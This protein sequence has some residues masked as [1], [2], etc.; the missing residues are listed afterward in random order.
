MGKRL[1]PGEGA[2]EFQP[3]DG[4][5]GRDRGSVAYLNMKER[6]QPGDDGVPSGE[7]HLLDPPPS[8]PPNQEGGLR[9]D[10]RLDASK[11]SSSS[12]SSASL[13]AAAATVFGPQNDVSSCIR[14]G[15]GDRRPEKADSPDIPD[16]ADTLDEMDDSLVSLQG[17]KNGSAAAAELL[18]L[19]D[20]FRSSPVESTPRRTSPASQL[21]L[22]PDL[23]CPPVARRDVFL[24]FLPLILP[25][26]ENGPMPPISSDADERRSTSAAPSR[27][28][29]VKLSAAISKPKSSLSGVE[30]PLSACEGL[31]ACSTSIRGVVGVCAVDVDAEASLL[32]S[33]C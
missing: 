25:E 19:P 31:L 1:G 2:A 18:L 28:A 13:A 10:G 30:S 22:R 6:M 27:K 8:P 4:L 12:S 17:K 15:D 20:P 7:A 21:I 26:E 33:V 24:E 16:V 5:V 9:S 32:L 14:C 3:I 29:D 11:S 23:P